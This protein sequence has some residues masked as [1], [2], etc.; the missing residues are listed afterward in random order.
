MVTGYGMRFHMYTPPPSSISMH[1]GIKNMQRAELSG[2]RQVRDNKE[3]GWVRSNKERRAFAV[4]VEGENELPWKIECNGGR[5]VHGALFFNRRRRR[6]E[7]KTT[8]GPMD[9]AANS[10]AILRARDTDSQERK[11]HPTNERRIGWRIL[12]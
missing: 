7:G 3:Y 12:L 4:G 9:A 8:H 6:V 2:P 10:V 5:E 1:D 11:R